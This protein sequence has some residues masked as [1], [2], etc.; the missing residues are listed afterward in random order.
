MRPV[1]LFNLPSGV[2]SDGGG[3]A[4]TCIV[5]C[6][7]SVSAIA[8]FGT[9]FVPGTPVSSCVRSSCGV[10]Y[11]AIILQPWDLVAAALA[12]ASGLFIVAQLETASALAIKP[13]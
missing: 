4:L 9:P 12:Y 10:E 2:C 11:T 1:V 6:M 3:L 7:P 5:P 13:P 8:V